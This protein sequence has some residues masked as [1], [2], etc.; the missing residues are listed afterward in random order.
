MAI[1]KHYDLDTDATLANNSDNTIASQKAVKTYVDNEVSTKANDADVVHKTGNE[2]ISGTKTF[3]GSTNSVVFNGGKNQLKIVV[4]NNNTNG[5]TFFNSSNKE[6]GYYQMNTAKNAMFMGYWS[7]SANSNPTKFGYLIENGSNK[8]QV[9]VPYSSSIGSSSTPIYYLPLAITNGTNSVMA[10][11]EGNIDISTLISGGGGN[12]DDVQINGTSIVSAG[13]ANIT[14]DSALSDTSENPVQNKVVKTALDDKQDTITSTNKLSASL[15]DGLSIVATSG[16]YNDLTDKPTIPTITDTYSATSSDGMSGKA[17]A[18]AISNKADKATSLSGYGIT[19]AY[20]KTEIDG[21]VS[22]AM[23]FKGTVASYSNLP[24]TGN[25]TGDMYNV[26]DTGAN[27]AWDG[28][29]WDK[30]SENIDLSG[31]VPTSRTINGKALTG[32]ISLSASDVGALPDSTTIP[33]GT[34]KSV[35]VQA[36]TGLSSS[37]ST[38]QT[39]T[40]NTTISIASGY[41]LPTT[42]EWNSK[43]DALPAQSGNNGKFLTTNGSTMS[44]ATVDALPSQSGQS[45]KFLTTDGTS[46]SWTAPVTWTYHSDT[47]TME[48]D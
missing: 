16:S 23:H 40:L 34:V 31:Y 41:K 46:S 8:Y 19:D 27:Y 7:S 37:T 38:A 32:N 11:S 48:V 33:Q 5:I 13:I 35:R 3:T 9:L 20:T 39:E 6:V 45:G 1:G 29:A 21:M 47:K 4:P 14:I 2:S 24:A 30:L 15:V 22:A 17:V 43:Q 44:W 28:T 26:T 25:K 42:T 12:V 36:G 10:D 18:S